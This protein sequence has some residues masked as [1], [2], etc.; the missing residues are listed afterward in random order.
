MM[1]INY[2]LKIYAEL[3]QYSD[4]KIWNFNSLNELPGLKNISYLYRRQIIFNLVKQGKL[5]RIAP[6]LYSLALKQDQ[7]D[8]WKYTA[9]ISENSAVCYSAA[10]FIHGFIN[11]EPNKIFMLTARGKNAVR[12]KALNFKG[13]NYKI[14]RS[15]NF[16]I[17]LQSKI[18]NNTQ[19]IVTDPEKTILDAFNNPLACIGFK[20]AIDLFIENRANLNLELMADY[21]FKINSAAVKRLGWVLEKT[22]NTGPAC[23]K[24]KALATKGFR[25]LDK[26]ASKTGIYNNE[27]KLQENFAMEFKESYKKELPVELL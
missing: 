26:G 8:V 7:I 25:L 11:Q 10:L 12:G 2:P 5:V 15:S 23:L 20:A 24:L 3:N 9:A 6:G 13:Y 27:W 21:A 14:V 16:N 18:I 17:G 19:L 22:G 1:N 4:T